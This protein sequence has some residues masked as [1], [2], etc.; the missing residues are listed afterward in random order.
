VDE[1]HGER[2]P[3]DG[4][5]LADMFGPVDLG[6]APDTV[7]MM[8]RDAVTYLPGDILAKLDR[9]SMA[10]G[11]ETRLPLLDHRVAEVAARIP[12]GTKIQGGVGKQVMRKL[13]FR[14]V[15]PSLIERP[16][17]GFAVPIGEWL[18]GPLRPWAEEL[19]DPKSLSERGFDPAPVRA[20]WEAHLERRGDWAASLWFV[21]M[22]QAWAEQ[23]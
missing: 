6:A 1:W 23:D 13:L 20:R 14:H 19:L 3:V 2:S 5:G 18:R 17:T 8:Y 12:L 9:A 16:K 4:G 22:F 7:R 21:L 15:P 10:V 11:L